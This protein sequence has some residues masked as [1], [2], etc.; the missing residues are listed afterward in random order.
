VVATTGWNDNDTAA[1]AGG[2]CRILVDGNLQIGP[3]IHPGQETGTHSVE[4]VPDGFFDG[5]AAVTGVSSLLSAGAH[6]FELQC[7]E[8]DADM[9]FNDSALSAVL[10][11]P[12]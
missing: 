1:K 7:N 11:G 6:V 3:T 8:R 2:N 12:G 9:L 4:L 10:L 5:A